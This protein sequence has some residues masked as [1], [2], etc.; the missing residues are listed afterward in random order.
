[1]S[2]RRTRSDG[3]DWRQFATSNGF[4]NSV[5][6]GVV[7]GHFS[8]CP[9]FSIANLDGQSIK[10]VNHRPANLLRFEDNLDAAV[11]LVAECL[12][13]ARTVFQRDGMRDHKR[14]I[15]LALLDSKQ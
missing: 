8:K 1:M 2:W 4:G 13:H 3:G 9:T 14:G 5:D 6:V 11:F 7:L 12:V 15:D 10:A